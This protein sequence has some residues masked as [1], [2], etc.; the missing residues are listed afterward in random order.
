M[1]VQLLKSKFGRMG[2]RV[3]VGPLGRRFR[4][5][6]RFTLDVRSD[7]KGEYFDIQALDYQQV[8]M[9]VLDVRPEM[10]QFW[11]IRRGPRT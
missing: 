8:E 3:E 5:N 7:R 6:T 11:G 1:D 2:A 9:T 4:L 10:R